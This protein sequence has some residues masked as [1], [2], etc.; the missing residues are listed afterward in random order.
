MELEHCSAADSEAWF[1]TGNYKIKTTSKIE[2]HFVARPT[3]GLEAL[4]MGRWPPMHVPDAVER[5]SKPHAVFESEWYAIGE[6]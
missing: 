5:T 3:D 1:E 4:G 2:W 6:L